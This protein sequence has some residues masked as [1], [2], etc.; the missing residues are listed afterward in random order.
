[1]KNDEHLTRIN[2][3]VRLKNDDAKFFGKLLDLNDENGKTSQELIQ[4][5]FNVGL[6][7]ISGN[8]KGASLAQAMNFISGM[9]RKIDVDKVI[10][11]GKE[12]EFNT[13]TRKEIMFKYN[14]KWNRLKL[15]YK[16]AT[17]PL[18]KKVGG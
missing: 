8:F 18:I 7:F 17:V 2:V 14:K 9:S 5:I 12:A 13:T 10:L 3:K 1:M 16:G 15:Q 11:N 6:S 4:F